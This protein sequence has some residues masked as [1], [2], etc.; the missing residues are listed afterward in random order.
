MWTEDGFPA[1][2]NVPWQLLIRARFAHEIEGYV[3]STVVRGVSHFAGA[4]LSA[5]VAKV[6]LDA[7]AE[8]RRS[9]VELGAEERVRILNAVADWDGE[10]CPPWWP[11]PFPPRPKHLGDIDDPLIFEVLGAAIE[12]AR[13]VGAKGLAQ[14]LAQVAE[15][16]G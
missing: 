8:S 5:E 14:N 1:A 10:I 6:A 12:L 13:S 4:R 7:V 2:D 15:Q 11:W 9:P 16:L 3:A